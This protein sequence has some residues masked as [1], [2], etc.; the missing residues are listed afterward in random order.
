MN[1]RTVVLALIAV[2]IAAIAGLLVKSWLSE[3]Q[4]QA[5]Q[6]AQNIEAT[7]IL[8]AAQD[9]PIGKILGPKD[10]SWRTWPKDGLIGSYIK[11]EDIA[12]R[13][14]QGLVVRHGIRKGEPIVKNRLVAQGERGF[15]SAVLAPEMRAITLSVT[16]T[17]GLAGLVYPGDRVDVI[18]VHNVRD[19]QGIERQA[20]ETVLRNARILAV[21]D[22]MND[23]S[24]NK[25]AVGKTATLEVPESMMERM[26]V[27]QRMGNLT[28][29]LRS[30]P[31]ST[32]ENGFTIAADEGVPTTS[33]PSHTF[34][35]EI[36]TLLPPLTEESQ[37]TVS[38][39]ANTSK[40]RIQGKGN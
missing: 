21:D 26:A 31:R 29:A 27:L 16:R 19:S 11:N 25:P 30:L 33:N 5:Q 17:S 38:R 35:A 20:A 28:L 10:F 23:Q 37:M 4:R 1:R 8:V 13:T 14:I 12:N 3:S 18:L 40:V 34:D 7:K 9:L 6:S 24:A 2:G 32:D 39:G 15:L 36:S 22:R